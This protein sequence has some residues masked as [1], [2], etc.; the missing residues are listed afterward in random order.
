MTAAPVVSVI[1]PSYNH[2]AFVEKAIES[3]LGQT[4]KDIELIIVDDGSTD[5][6]PKKIAAIKDPRITFIPLTEN[7]RQHPRNL[8]LSLAKGKFIAFQNSDD[9][10]EPNKLERQLNFMENN[11]NVAVCF[12]KVKIIDDRGKETSGTWLEGMFD[13]KNMTRTEW[14]KRFFLQGNCLCITSSLVR[15][16]ALSKTEPFCPS[17]F[18]L[19][20]F[21]LWVRMAAIGDLHIIE[22]VLTKVRVVKDKNLSSPSTKWRTIWVFE[23]A[24]VLS[25]YAEAPIQDEVHRVF[26]GMAQFDGSLVSN[27]LGLIKLAWEKGS[28]AYLFF[29]DQ[30]LIR[31][32][33]D[34]DLREAALSLYGG[35]LIN[36]FMKKRNEIEV[37]IPRGKK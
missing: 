7:R 21:D 20:D 19:S 26:E 23:H 8:A 18:F 30:L 27:Y 37:L 16:S 31:I 14:L 5:D 35:G 34:R 11:S 33:E 6:T 2:A 15:S 3:V 13:E 1:M 36:D 10:W 4:I 32:I 25:R 29:A 24:K 28:P 9:E 22:G 17:L 12:T